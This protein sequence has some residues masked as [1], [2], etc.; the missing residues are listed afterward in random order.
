MASDTRIDLLKVVGLELTLREYQEDVLDGHPPYYETEPLVFGCTACGKCCERPGLVYMTDDDIEALAHHFG[1]TTG[2]VK[3]SMLERDGSDWVVQVDE[4]APCVF[5]N[6]HDTSCKIH[7]V[8]PLQC[9]TYPFWA[10]V[11]GTRRAW[12]QE[13]KLCPG[14]GEGR[15]YAADEVRRILVGAQA[16]WGDDDASEGD[17]G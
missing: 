16:S 7:P 3:V 17:A 15:A 11:V 12:R 8:K 9:R 2:E 10:E 14:I 1:M 4:T 5:Y 13:Q 6:A